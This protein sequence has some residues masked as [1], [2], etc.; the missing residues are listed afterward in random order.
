V[1]RVHRR[2]LIG[3]AAAVFALTG[4]GAV[5]LFRTAPQ[6]RAD[7]PPALVGSFAQ[8]TAND[9]PSPAP[10]AGFTANGK[11]TSLADFRGRVVLLNFWATWCGPCVAEMPSLDRLEAALGG[12][13]FVVV[14][15]SED[16]NPAVVEPFFAFGIRG[17]PTSALIDRKGNV[18]GRIE[19]PAE[20]DSAQAKALI[21][22]YMSAGGAGT[23]A[24]L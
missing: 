4:A 17:L 24:Q 3:I 18:V 14:A 7:A 6:P 11:P 2:A 15:V 13:D 1:R 23:Q 22:H 20:W 5:A 8:F 16:R 12:E 19:G 9:A 10:Q 21:R